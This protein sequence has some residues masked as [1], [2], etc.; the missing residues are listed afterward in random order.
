MYNLDF[1]EVAKGTQSAFLCL[2][3]YKIVLLHV[4]SV[5]IVSQLATKMRW[6]WCLAAELL[7]DFLETAKTILMN[8]FG[9]TNAPA[10]KLQS[11]PT[12][13]LRWARVGRL[14]VQGRWKIINLQ[15]MPLRYWG[16]D[17]LPIGL[18]SSPE[19]QGNVAITPPHAVCLHLLSKPANKLSA[20]HIQAR[21]PPR[22]E[23]HTRAQKS[24]C[25]ST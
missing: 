9:Q 11:S 23:L 19:Y 14:N 13:G 22:S 7:V 15:A 6:S 16:R 17:A 24:L 18:P 2:C 8:S 3:S 12:S 5:L 21:W 1:R 10:L 25:R 4:S 20:R